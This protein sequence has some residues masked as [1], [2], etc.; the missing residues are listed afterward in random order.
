M[1]KHE[2]CP[3]LTENEILKK[4]ADI[5]LKFKCELNE[6]ITNFKYSECKALFEVCDLAKGNNCPA[7]MY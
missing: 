2:D 1:R 5:H 6:L 7:H 3:A 4:A